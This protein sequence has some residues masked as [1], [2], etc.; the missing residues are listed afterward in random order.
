MTP[1][2]KE[3]CSDLLLQCQRKIWEFDGSTYRVETTMHDLTEE[4]A[5]RSRRVLGAYNW[6]FPEKF[7]DFF[8]HNKE[9]RNL[10]LGDCT[11]P[12]LKNLRDTAIAKG[13]FKAEFDENGLV[14]TCTA[15][16]NPSMNINR[17]ITDSI[18]NLT[19]VDDDEGKSKIIRL[20]ASF[21]CTSI[22][23]AAFVRV[24]K[25]PWLFRNPNDAKEGV[26]HIFQIE[27]VEGEVILKRDPDWANNK[28]LESHGLAL[29]T[30]CDFLL[31]NLAKQADR[32]TEEDICKA[33]AS[34]GLYF[35]AIDYPTAPSAGAWEEVPLP[36]G[37][38]WDTEAIRQGLVS[39]DQ[40]IFGFN[41][42]DEYRKKIQNSA[43]HI[44]T[45]AGKFGSDSLFTDKN[46]LN[47][48]IQAGTKQVRLR[49]R[50]KAEAPGMRSRDA[51]LAFLAQSDLDLV[52][53]KDPSERSIETARLYIN[54]LEDLELGLVRK[55]GMIRYEPFALKP[56]KDRSFFDSYLNLNYWISFDEEGYFNPV[57]TKLIR[58]FESFDASDPEILR[59]RTKLGI[60]DR[61][62]E[63]FLVT[64]MAIAY[65][66]QARRLLLPIWSGSESQRK[67]AH[68]LFMRCKDKAYEYLKRGY[69]RVTPSK[70]K[71][72][73]AA[74]KSNGE[75]CEPWKIPE[76]YEWIRIRANIVNKGNE[77]FVERT[78]PGANTPLAWASASL[79]I[80]TD[81]VY[82]LL[83]SEKLIK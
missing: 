70:P 81:A 35:Q 12:G 58:D 52:D 61:E 71:T 80:A 16:E 30:F 79:K 6:Y 33:I 73:K 60:P 74:I 28:R 48:L 68:D 53:I 40:L 14:K 36:G 47:Q 24:I 63:W 49:I 66:K 54:L 56:K 21:Y 31:G 39:L 11:I 32:D 4:R 75:D 67:T 41:G 82:L 78:L 5:R 46:V 43:K 77:G 13:L 42:N 83:I 8:I 20:L 72:S 2:L 57:R 22:E 3:T 26:A 69:A 45:L 55:N 27:Q 64:E 38:S 76:A 1:K 23:Q 15:K 10:L 7:E 25:A 18:H 65:T 17:W 50:Q 44:V 59:K 29:R 34:L 51:S 62:A 19:L 9:I 37:L